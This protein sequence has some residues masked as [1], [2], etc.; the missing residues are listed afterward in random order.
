MPLMRFF[1]PKWQHP[2]PEVRRQAVEVMA[3]DHAKALQQ[4]AREDEFAEIRKA[5]LSR[6]HDLKFLWK[7]IG[8]EQDRD[9]RE[10]ANRHLSKIL[11][12]VNQEHHSLT[13]RQDFLRSH[14]IQEVLEYVA[15]HGA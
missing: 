13:T 11:A 6:I 8:D 2:N 10:F 4:V 5:A 7:A 12:G 3:E 1:R 14:P 15:L 9:V